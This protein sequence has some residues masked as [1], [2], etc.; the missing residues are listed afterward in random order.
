M[1]RTQVVTTKNNEN[2]VRQNSAPYKTYSDISRATK[3]RYTGAHY[4]W[5]YQSCS[6]DFSYHWTDRHAVE[7]PSCFESYKFP[8]LEGESSKGA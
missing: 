8:I 5:G 6:K 7:C 3:D 2:E 1:K 4:P